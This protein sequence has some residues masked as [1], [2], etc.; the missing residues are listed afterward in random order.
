MAVKQPPVAL[1]SNFKARISS[2]LNASI[3]AL[4]AHLEARLSLGGGA[5]TRQDTGVF[6]GYEVELG[7]EGAAV[8]RH[9]CTEINS[10]HDTVENCALRQLHALTALCDMGGL[11]QEK[12]VSGAALVRRHLKVLSA[13][14]VPA[15]GLLRRTFDGVDVWLHRRRP[16]SGDDDV[17]GSPSLQ[18]SAL[19]A[20]VTCAAEV[21][22]KKYFQEMHS[23]FVGLKKVFPESNWDNKTISFHKAAIVWESLALVAS[24]LPPSSF[25][26]EIL[27]WIKMFES[28]LRRAWLNDQS[29]WSFSS[30]RAIAVRWHSKALKTKKQKTLFRKWA[31]EHVTRFLG[32][33]GKSM[34]GILARL[35]GPAT[36]TCGPLQALGALVSVLPDAELMRS[37]L[38]LM[39]KDV[40][41]YQLTAEN[42]ETAKYMQFFGEIGN[43]AFVR[44]VQQLTMEKRQSAR[45][46]DSSMCLIAL[47]HILR[48]MDGVIAVNLEDSV[49][50][51]NA[52]QQ[53]ESGVRT[54]DLPSDTDGRVAEL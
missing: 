16:S 54:N 29:L 37:T 6:G 7:G 23:W 51:G 33:A 20:V 35:G 45:V 15:L 10:S 25:Q 5:S 27:E 12:R 11:R 49:T 14:D 50:Y 19:V 46:D 1:E 38:G 42:Q 34:E 41:R 26:E 53:A 2:K 52:A 32:S 44:D 39:E 13:P 8:W 4:M 18:A 28:Y 43:G 24:H 30:A 21:G 22:E 48:A 31:Q 47:T 36:Y 40:D 17:D 3:E 9:R